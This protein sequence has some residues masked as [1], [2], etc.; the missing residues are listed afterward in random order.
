MAEWGLVGLFLGAFLAGGVLFFPSEALLLTLLAAGA[1]PLACVGVATAGNV[2][3]GLTLYG[4][5]RLIA[6][7]G[8][9]GERLAAR[10]AQ[11]PDALERTRARLDRWGPLALVLSWLPVV[12]D[13]LPLSA[14][15]ARL[16][17]LSST[18]W[19]TVGKGLRYLVVAGVVRAAL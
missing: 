18:A 16:P 14:G 1:S 11:D 2:L 17:L 5:G 15:L 8:R 12:G 10:Y 6:R 13:V 7:G 19:L 3:G 9:L 4:I